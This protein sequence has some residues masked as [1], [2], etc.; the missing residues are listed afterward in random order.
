MLSC[1]VSLSAPECPE[2][3]D[4]AMVASCR[5]WGQLGGH[6]D[7]LGQRHER[8]PGQ[9]KNLHEVES[10]HHGK[11]LRQFENSLTLKC[12]QVI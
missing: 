3:K 12:P 2:D 4:L 11:I 1:Q 10:G 8:F 7:I 6:L 9:T 5:L